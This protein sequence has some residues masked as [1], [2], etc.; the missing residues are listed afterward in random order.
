MDRF[1]GIPYVEH[2]RDYAGADCWGLIYLYYRD[3]LGRPVPSYLAEMQEREFRPRGI[4]PLVDAE[5]EAHWIEATEPQQGDVVL[6]RNG[7]HHNHVGIR[8]IGGRLL[9]SDGPGPS[10]I[11]RLDALH[12][13]NRIVGFYRLA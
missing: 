8:L 5:R 1:V 7:R 2:G 11:E 9:H 4:G 12:L 10:R 6:M 3:V 13:R